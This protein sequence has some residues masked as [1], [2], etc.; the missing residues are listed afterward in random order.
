M[1]TINEIAAKASCE[2]S[3][4]VFIAYIPTISK[5]L[6]LEKSVCACVLKYLI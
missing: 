6:F 3:I 1:T 5:Q 2:G 4:N